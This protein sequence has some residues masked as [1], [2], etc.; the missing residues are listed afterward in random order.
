MCTVR[1]RA[2]V[3]SSPWLL[4][5]A[6]TP[7]KGFTQ[8]ISSQNPRTE[9]IPITDM[10]DISLVNGKQMLPMYRDRGTNASWEVSFLPAVSYWSHRSSC[11]NCCL[12][13]FLE[14]KDVKVQIT[15][16]L[17]YGGRGRLGGL[18]VVNSCISYHHVHPFTFWSPSVTFHL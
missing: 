11:E 2:R 5:Q 7:E 3:S 14:W 13:T 10:N 12:T 16:A 4:H 8:G 9:L 18:F 1:T 17:F 15:F 6:L